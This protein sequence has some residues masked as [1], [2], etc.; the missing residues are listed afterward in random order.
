MINVDEK[1][2][3]DVKIKRIVEN[4]FLK[5]KEDFDI[6][7]FEIVDVKNSNAEISIKY[8]IDNT[9]TTSSS[10]TK[11]FFRIRKLFIERERGE[12]ASAGEKVKEKEKFE[13][14]RERKLRKDEKEEDK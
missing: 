1:S 5:K 4:E 14:K 12:D 3:K 8:H 11:F 7:I 13:R 2:A 9:T 10:F 6:I